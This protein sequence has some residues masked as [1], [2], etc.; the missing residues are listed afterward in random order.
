MIGNLE[1]PYYAVGPDFLELTLQSRAPRPKVRRSPNPCQAQKTHGNSPP[2]TPTL[3]HID[4]WIFDL[5]N[6]LY[7]ETCS[8]FDQ[9]NYKMK[10]YM[11]NLLEVT[12]QEADDLRLSFYAKH[13]TTLNGLMQEYGADP[14]PFLDFVH[15]I[16]LSAISPAP[17]L[18]ALLSAL[19]GRCLV[20]TNGSAVHA[21]NV[22][23]KLAIEHVFE[24][25]FDIIASDFTPK[26][27]AKAFEQFITAFDIDPKTAIMFEDKIENLEVPHALGMSTVWVNEAKEAREPTP[28]QGRPDHI[29]PEHIHYVTETVDDFLQ[30]LPP[31]GE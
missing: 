16:D 29:H 30:S 28:P 14:H 11:S 3:A 27:K 21:A 18:G 17:R 25:V 6:T 2:L 10:S 24:G 22:L 15:Q 8:I 13:G 31:M 23:R 5:D 9:I 1:Q 20:H 7:P 19:P 4:T 12:P 26:P